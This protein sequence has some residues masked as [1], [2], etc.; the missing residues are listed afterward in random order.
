MAQNGKIRSN[1]A[2]NLSVARQVFWRPTIGLSGF[3]H[4]L[5]PSKRNDL[6]LMSVSIV[7]G[8]EKRTQED[9][10]PTQWRAQ[11]TVWETVY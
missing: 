8:S 3:L 5:L 10:L 6:A 9:Q 11:L 1:L 7:A 2:G 4:H